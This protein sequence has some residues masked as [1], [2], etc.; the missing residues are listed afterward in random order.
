M[1]LVICVFS[2][3][4]AQLPQVAAADPADPAD[5]EPDQDGPEVA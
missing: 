3:V 5:P 2:E 1:I 4:A